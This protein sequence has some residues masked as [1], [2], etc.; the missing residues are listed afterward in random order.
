[1]LVLASSLFGASISSRER[2]S[3]LAV[4]LDA[5]AV[6]I[7]EQQHPIVGHVLDLVRGD[8]VG[9]RQALPTRLHEQ[10]GVHHVLSVIE[11]QLVLD[12]C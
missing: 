5:Q 12:F 11:R 1:M 3:L 6:L 8:L 9:V 10:F 2:I 4:S 7:H